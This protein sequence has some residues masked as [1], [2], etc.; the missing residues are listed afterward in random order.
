MP[1]AHGRPPNEDPDGYQKERIQIAD[2]EHVLEN[3]GVVP[4]QE[5]IHQRPNPHGANDP[6]KHVV[7]RDARYTREE[8][9]HPRARAERLTD[10][11]PDKQRLIWLAVGGE[12]GVPDA[13]GEDR[14]TDVNRQR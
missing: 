8:E 6:F 12:D 10:S 5:P 13:H 4:E 3:R 7:A 14:P 9:A 11:S 1:L 2:P